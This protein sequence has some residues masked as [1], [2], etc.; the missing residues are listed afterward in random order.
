M[1]CVSLVCQRFF[2]ATKY[3]KFANERVLSFTEGCSDSAGPLPI[4]VNSERIYPIVSISNVNL[5]YD[6][7][8]FWISNGDNIEEIYFINGLLRKEEF[9]NVVKYTPNLK[10]L[11]IETNN[12]FKNWEIIKNGFER[13]VLLN[14]VNNFSLS[15]NN[16]MNRDIFD[17]LI[18]MMPH[19][20]ELNLSH[21]F[22]TMPP[23]ERNRMLDYI[24][25][26]VTE[27]C[28]IISE[29]QFG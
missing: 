7:E 17:H 2:E 9:I 3:W 19:I 12:Y 22:H 21:C 13:R 8:D 28:W 20:T 15:G 5:D 10:V 25:A 4:F 6:S 24:L 27:N 18:S 29:F 16:Y 14:F 1:N 23:V 11:K 26:Y